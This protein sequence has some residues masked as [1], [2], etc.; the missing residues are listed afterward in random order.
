MVNVPNP[1]GAVEETA[2]FGWVGET[3]GWW[4]GKSRARPLTG[5]GVIPRA[6]GG[7]LLHM[8]P[9]HPNLNF[10]NIFLYCIVGYKLT[11]LPY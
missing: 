5:P 8:E 4:A 9:T 7:G 1:S 2:P 3:K 10:F 6:G 11:L